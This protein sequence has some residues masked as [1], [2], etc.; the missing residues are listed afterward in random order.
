MAA[1][2]R[3]QAVEPDQR[4]RRRQGH[5]RGPT[6]QR[7]HPGLAGETCTGE[8]AHWLSKGLCCWCRH[9]YTP[10]RGNV[11]RKGRPEMLRSKVA[12]SAMAAG[13]LIGIWG[14]AAA[15]GAKPPAAGASTSRVPALVREELL[16]RLPGVAGEEARRAMAFHARM[17]ASGPGPGFKRIKG[18]YSA[19]DATHVLSAQF[20]RTG[21]TIASLTAHAKWHL[22]FDPASF[23]RENDRP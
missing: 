11:T 7:D 23:S 5:H 1:P 12:S 9:V 17:A 20:L 15:G 13:L 3:S 22:S 10:G 19:T 2:L 14:V 4:C 16:S 6:N 21:T 18:G 8:V